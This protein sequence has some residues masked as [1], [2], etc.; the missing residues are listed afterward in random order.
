MTPVGISATIFVCVFGGALAGVG[1]RAVLPPHHLN[2][3]SKEV[4][5]LSMG[6]VATMTALVLGLLVASAKE[7]Y[8]TQGRELTDLSSRIVMLDRVL[9]HYGPET[10]TARDRFRNV[11]TSMLTHLE[12]DGE[13]SAPD[14][15]GPAANNELPFDLIQRLVPKDERQRTLQMRALTMALVLGEERWLMYEQGV[16]TYLRPLL[17]IVVAWLAVIFMSFGLYAPPNP[18]V[19]SALGIASLTVSTAMFLILEMYTPYSGIVRL[20]VA[21]LR[22]ALAHLGLP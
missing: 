7:S 21:P 22:S 4:V 10:Q 9:A 20:S 15:Q 1:L 18:V 6:L 13:S 11:V 5:K 3:E 16:E 2:Q 19:T 8:D 12:A 14:A 17:I